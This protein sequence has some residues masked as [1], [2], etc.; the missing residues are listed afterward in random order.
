M[1]MST[2]RDLRISRKFGYAFGAICLLIAVLGASAVGGFLK[3]KSAVQEVALDVMP[4]IRILGDLRYDIS[5]IRRTDALLQLCDNSACTTRLTTKRTTYIAG[6]NS[7]ISKYGGMVSYPGERELYDTIRQ[8]VADYLE[9]SDR[10]RTLAEGGKAAEAEQLLLGPQAQKSFNGA[11]DAVLADVA[12]NDKMGAQ[13]GTGAIHLVELLVLVICA[14]AVVTVLLCGGIGVGL[15]RLMVPPLQE[16][17][18]ALEQLA[19]KD[20]TGSVV[21]RGSDEVGRL[22]TAINASVGSMREVLRTLAAGAETLSAAAEELSVRSNQTSENAQTQTT[23]TGQIAVAAQQM[24]ASIGEISNNAGSA[25]AASRQSFEAA[26]EGETIMKATN[27]TMERIGSANQS[28]TQRVHSLANRSAEIGRVA[29]VI[30]EISEQTN[31]LAL[32]AAIEAARA[33]EH[34]RGFA[35]VAGEVR[36]LAERT[37][38]AT[39]EIA[40][41]IRNI[42]EETLHTSE[43][44]KESSTDVQAGI[45]ETAR[46]HTSLEATIAT[47]KTVEQMLNLIATATTEQ[48]SASGEISQA[49][50]YISDLATSSADAATETAEACRGLSALANQLDGVIRQFRT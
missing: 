41:T 46:A 1:P 45:N 28:I 34:G 25:A 33:G 21:S 23:K 14:L 26:T 7:D 37:K 42:Q 17:T 38:G 20:L 43:M 50:S 27:S 5:T 31:L 35:V 47:T 44:M 3:I 48:T 24:T 29:T 11:S 36:R 8:N 10:S 15:T 39:E 16:A 19:D 6:F 40:G 9:V 13:I 22:S 32:N 30:H 18:K 49:A 4:S 2:L 12:L